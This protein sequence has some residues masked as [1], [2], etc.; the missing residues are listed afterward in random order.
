MLGIFYFLIFKIL[1]SGWVQPQVW[2]S[3]KLMYTR[4]FLY[5]EYSVDFSG[6]FPQ[7]PL[8]VMI[9]L[10]HTCQLYIYCISK[11][12]SI[13]V[14]KTIRQFHFYNRFITESPYNLLFKSI[15]YV[16]V[17]TNHCETGPRLGHSLNCD[18]GILAGNLLYL[19]LWTM[20]ICPQM[21][22]IWSVI[23]EQWNAELNFLHTN[24][25]STLGT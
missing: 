16:V 19:Q 5:W 11:Q 2:H 25:Y 23:S 1:S 20:I 15:S 14:H 18:V 9:L 3:L 8:L 10:N 6:L 22:K 21:T 17:I 12:L 7:W 13:H 4:T 24:E